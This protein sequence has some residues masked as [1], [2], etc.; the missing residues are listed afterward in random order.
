MDPGGPQRRQVP[1]RERVHQGATPPTTSHFSTAPLQPAGHRPRGRQRRDGWNR[2][3]ARV[4]LAYTYPTLHHRERRT[5]VMTLSRRGPRSILNTFYLLVTLGI[6]VGGSLWLDHRSSTV[7]A[8]VSGKTEEIH[9][10]RPRR[11]RDDRGAAGVVRLAPPGRYPVDPVPRRLPPLRPL[12]R[13]LDWLGDSGAGR[14]DSGGPGPDAAAALDRRR[15]RRVAAGG[16]GGDVA[17]FAAGA[18]WTAAGFP[19]LLPAAE[20]VILPAAETE[21]RVTGVSLVER[22]P[23]GGGPKR[24]NERALGGGVGFRPSGLLESTLM[25]AGRQRSR[26]RDANRRPR[27]TTRSRCGCT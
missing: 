11:L 17:V 21:G 25:V 24:P 9:S 26:T 3:A 23:G 5:G 22:A 15:V 16:P 19:M 12:G 10:R 1:G 14:P 18:L 20:P 7:L 6:M 8:T 4:S 2:L 27:R 13:P